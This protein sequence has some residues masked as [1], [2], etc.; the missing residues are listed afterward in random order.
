MES[1]FTNETVNYHIVENLVRIL[2]QADLYNLALLNRNFY[3]LVVPHLFRSITITESEHDP[4]KNTSYIR[5]SYE[6]SSL[7]RCRLFLR[8][9]VE[10]PELVILIRELHLGRDIWF[11][12]VIHGLLSVFVDGPKGNYLEKVSCEH[13]QLIWNNCSEKLCYRCGGFRGVLDVNKAR[14]TSLQIN[15]AEQKWTPN[16]RNLEHLEISGTKSGAL[17][18]VNQDDWYNLKSLKILYEPYWFMM[19]NFQTPCPMNLQELSIDRNIIRGEPILQDFTNY[20]DCEKNLMR[21]CLLRKVRYR[22]K[23]EDLE[24]LDRYLPKFLSHL[25]THTELELIIALKGGK[26]LNQN[27]VIDLCHHHLKFFKFESSKLKIYNNCNR[28]YTK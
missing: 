3:N 15:G 20:F 10:N 4:L 9:L 23:F 2:P 22:F 14:M 5:T 12:D 26:S 17:Q 21:N 6:S 18:L 28:F 13:E 25:S 11:K 16:F 27:Q 19:K 1:V 8:S 24:L 7:H